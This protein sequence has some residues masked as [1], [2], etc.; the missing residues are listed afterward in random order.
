MINPLTKSAVRFRLVMGLTFVLLVVAATGVAIYGVGV[1]NKYAAEVSNFVY[2]A[3]T[4][5]Q[6]LDNI[7]KLA[8]QMDS[9]PFAVKQA[10][11]IVA[12]SKSY[13]YQNVIVNDLQRMANSAGVQIISY[14]FASGASSDSGGAPAPEAATPPATAA[15]AAGGA[16]VGG[17]AL[18]QR[19]AAQ[20]TL[21]SI[22][23]NITLK[24]PIDYKSLLNFIHLIE[25][26]ATKM[27]IANVTLSAAEEGAQVNVD[28]LTIEVYVE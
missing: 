20:S 11:Q 17:A 6:K 19:P 9:Q 3:D 23:F 24:T 16:G 12:E 21:K 14:D 1:L 8:E 18:P 5:E 27:Q 2:K 10:Q 13:R 22:S 25:Q 4:S 26:N 15:P 7:K 28:A